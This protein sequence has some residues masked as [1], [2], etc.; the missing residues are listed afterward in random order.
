MKLLIGK[1]NNNILRLLFISV[2]LITISACGDDSNPTDNNDDNNNTTS[3]TLKLDGDGFSNKSLST[4]TAVATYASVTQ[5]TVI[6]I[7][8]DED[9]QML[10]YLKGNKTGTFTF[11]ASNNDAL[12]NG[13]SV[14]SGSGQT[15]KYYLW[16]E[17]SGSIKITSYGS[18]GGKVSGTFTGKLYNVISD[19]EMTISG[20]FSA[21]RTVDVPTKVIN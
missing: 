16:K 10:I 6:S 2:F 20:S 3:S 9:V 5:M 14:T 17:Q 12:E 7:S 18:V 15:A 19:A 13:I 1:M 8:F 11:E 4:E 21:M